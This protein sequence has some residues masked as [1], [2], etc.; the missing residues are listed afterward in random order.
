MIIVSQDKLR[1]INF[2]RI[3]AMALYKNKQIIY[4][5]CDDGC[6]YILG[7]YLTAEEGLRAFAA[8]QRDIE[9][10]LRNPTLYATVN[11]PLQG[12]YLNED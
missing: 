4:N 5:C 11:I 2:D 3:N 9:M 6:D 10:A 1:I 8:V 12:E 7:S